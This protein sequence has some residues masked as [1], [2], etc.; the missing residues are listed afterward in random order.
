MVRLVDISMT[1]A[2]LRTAEEPLVGACGELRTKLGDHTFVARVEVRRVMAESGQG[3][4]AGGYGIGVAFLSLDVDNRRC[5]ERFLR[6]PSTS[7]QYT[8]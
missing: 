5:L 6:H 3:Q 4:A 7:T 8:G 1:G 2:L